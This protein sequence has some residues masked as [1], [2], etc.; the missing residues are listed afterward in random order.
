VGGWLVEEGKDDAFCSQWKTMLDYY[1]A[2]FFHFKG[3]RPAKPS[4]GEG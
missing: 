1:G 3:N 2:K 4:Y